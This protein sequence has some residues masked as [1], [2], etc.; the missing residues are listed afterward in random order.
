MGGW[1]RA[2]S[3]GSMIPVA[4]PIK[5]LKYGD[6]AVGFAKKLDKGL[7][8]SSAGKKARKAK[9]KVDDVAQKKKKFKCACKPAASVKWKGFRK[10]SLAPH[11][12]KHGHE[13]GNITQGEYFKKAKEFA[14]ETGKSFQ[15]TNVGNFVIKYDPDTR[16]T[17]IGH[18]KNREIRTF[19]KAD[20]RDEDPYNA[21]IELAKE[22]SRK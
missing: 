11:Y 1:E 16:R 10:N 7:S 6:E 19:Y 17:L 20:Y 18:I 3:C 2:I 14:T 15:E 13:F 21:A 12:E 5:A 22:L 9:D 4:K 8:N